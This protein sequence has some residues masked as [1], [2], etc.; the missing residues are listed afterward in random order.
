MRWVDISSL[1]Q[2]V[3]LFHRQPLTS[4]A[5]R[6]ADRRNASRVPQQQVRVADKRAF[7]QR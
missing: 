5:R 4:L 1:E 7:V 3:N 6:F 2:L